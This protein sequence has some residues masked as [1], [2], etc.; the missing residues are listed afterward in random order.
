MIRKE[1]SPEFKKRVAL[2]ALKEQKSVREIAVEYEVHPMQVCKWKKQLCDKA[3]LA[4]EPS[5]KRSAEQAVEMR[6][7]KLHEK[8]GQLTIELD[9]MKKKV[10]I[11]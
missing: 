6:E 7:A 2:E 10:G 5:A 8:I 9:W 11:A 1:R 3:G 4:F